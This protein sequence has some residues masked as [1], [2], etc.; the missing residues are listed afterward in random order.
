MLELLSVQVVR[1][2]A[3]CEGAGRRSSEIGYIGVC[4]SQNSR[5]LDA[6]KLALGRCVE[7]GRASCL[8]SG[9]LHDRNNFAEW[10]HS[11]AIQVHESREQELGLLL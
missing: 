6:P 1:H 7:P 4:G 3:N 5:P 9:C 8:L 2:C 10:P 11:N